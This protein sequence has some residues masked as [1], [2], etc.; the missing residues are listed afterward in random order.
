MTAFLV[1]L[2]ASH[3]WVS[4][5]ATPRFRYHA[6]FPASYGSL[7]SE[8]DHGNTQI[9]ID[10]PGTIAQVTDISS[11]SMKEE[12]ISPTTLTVGM[13]FIALGCT[14]V[15]WLCGS[16]RRLLPICSFD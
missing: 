2:E 15:M 9:I 16:K 11:A 8:R 14:V 13:M 6:L 10:S 4:P 7:Q 5:D 3:V 12:A 1:L